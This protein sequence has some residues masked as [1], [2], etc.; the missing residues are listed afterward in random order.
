MGG[1][2]SANLENAGWQRICSAR[3]VMTATA[4]LAPPDYSRAFRWRHDEGSLAE[5]MRFDREM[6]PA[7]SKDAWQDA[8][9][10]SFDDLVDMVNP[11]QHLP[12]LGSIY[13]AITGDAIGAVPRA[14]GGFL[15]GGPAGFAASLG[16]VFVKGATGRDP[17]E[18]MI[19]AIL[20]PGSQET[21]T[22]ALRAKPTQEERTNTAAEPTAAPAPAIQGPALQAQSQ[23]LPVRAFPARG[24]GAAIRAP[25]AAS[26]VAHSATLAAAGAA[27]GD[28]NWLAEQ[29]LL[30]LE[31][32][33]S[34]AR[35]GTLAR[36]NSSGMPSLPSPPKLDDAE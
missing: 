28:K 36:P 26:P 23:A 12:L 3:I 29:M 20:G 11:L 25:E 24:R 5:A 6:T 19:A 4:P 10:F 16:S 15:F 35:L 27:G 30:G 2:P 21:Q 32:Y 22:A 33:R 17:G 8:A 18:H 14:V 1:R 9:G 34:A 7:A 31:K 13:R